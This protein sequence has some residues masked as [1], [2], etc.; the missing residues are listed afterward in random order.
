MTEEIKVTIAAWACLLLL[1]RDT[2]YYPRL[3]TILVYPNAYIARNLEHKGGGLVEE[4]D[5][6]RIGEAWMDGV[7]VISWEDVCRDAAGEGDG[8]NVVL[9][10]FA[11]L[12]DFEDGLADGTP[13]LAHR[14]H[15]HAWARVFDEEYHPSSRAALG[16]EPCSTTTA[17]QPRRVLRRGNRVLL[18]KAR[19]A[20]AKASG[21]LRGPQD[22]LP[23]RSGRSSLPIVPGSGFQSDCPLYRERQRLAH[24]GRAK[25]LLSR[26]SGRLARRLA[27]PDGMSHQRP[28]RV[29]SGGRFHGFTRSST[30]T[31]S[32]G[33][34]TG[35][36]LYWSVVNRV[37]LVW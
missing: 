2:N 31:Q 36:V 9:H 23:A 20:A 8:V 10:E 1:H 19:R 29:Y 22:L 28:R 25:L 30:S 7:A 27:H 21:T 37:S 6:V 18:R 4:E 17:N 14:R 26:F 3:I 16:A 5:V 34:E 24:L 32:C 12:L 33:E 13:R 11:H 35:G 15:Y